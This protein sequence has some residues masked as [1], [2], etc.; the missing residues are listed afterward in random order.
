MN[1]ILLAVV[2]LVAMTLTARRLL[3]RRTNHVDDTRI[4]SRATLARLD[5]LVRQDVD[6]HAIR[7]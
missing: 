7:R 5:A 2:A 1:L 4:T 3:A 6:T